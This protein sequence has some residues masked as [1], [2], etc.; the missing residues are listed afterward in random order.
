MR[1]YSNYNIYILKK[2]ASF[3]LFRQTFY[4]MH[5]LY[6]LGGVHLMK[7]NPKSFNT[8]TQ[9]PNSDCILYN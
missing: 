1:I 3:L 8:C 6:S 5:F 2:I 7:F 9:Q 4:N